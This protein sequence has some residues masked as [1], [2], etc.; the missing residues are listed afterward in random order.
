MFGI[1]PLTYSRIEEATKEGLRSQL[2]HR[3]LGKEGKTVSKV[4]PIIIFL[5]IFLAITLQLV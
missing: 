5:A 2:I 4:I 1:E 3:N